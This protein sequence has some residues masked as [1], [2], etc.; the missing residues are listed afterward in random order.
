[1][2]LQLFWLGVRRAYL[3]ADDYLIPR[4]AL[5]SKAERSF[6]RAAIISFG[7]IEEVTPVI[8]CNT[9]DLVHVFLTLGP[10]IFPAT[11]GPTTHSKDRQFQG[12]FPALTQ[13]DRCV[14]GDFCCR[15]IHCSSW[16]PRGL[17]SVRDIARRHRFFLLQNRKGSEQ[18][19][20]GCRKVD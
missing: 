6:T 14:F 17:H 4:N 10:P 15:K 5:Q 8:H 7:C 20:I 3:G 19:V 9:N 16:N 1:M 11:I 18:T 12:V 2:F 13:L